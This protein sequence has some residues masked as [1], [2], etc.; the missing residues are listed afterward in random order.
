VNEGHDPVAN[1]R[2]LRP[3]GGGIEFGETGA[4]AIVREIREELD[5][6]VRDVHYLGTVEN[7]F[8]YLGEP[9]HEVVLVYDARFADD[10]LYDRPYLDGKE[11]E[12]GLIRASWRELDDIAELL[13]PAGL[14]ALVRSKLA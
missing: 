5:A 14:H 13:V 4:R 3:L 6:E 9:F 10:R 2:F 12:G 11:T 1:S 8:T 7:L